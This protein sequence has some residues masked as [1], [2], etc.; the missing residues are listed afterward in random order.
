MTTE[1]ALDDMIKA[2]NRICTYI[3]EKIGQYESL[4]ETYEDWFRKEVNHSIEKFTKL[5]KRPEF[6][7]SQ[8]W[9]MIWDLDGVKSRQ[10]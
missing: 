8:F 9:I 10:G 4:G 5:A 1:D 7:E 3:V 2:M 6:G